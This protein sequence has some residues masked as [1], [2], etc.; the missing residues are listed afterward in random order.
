MEKCDGEGG[1]GVEI[2]ATGR[3]IAPFLRIYY[4]IKALYDDARS[5]WFYG[6]IIYEE[7]WLV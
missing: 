2:W 3:V 7:Q 5:R 6:F 1:H 4:K